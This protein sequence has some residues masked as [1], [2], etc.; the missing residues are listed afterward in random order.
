MYSDVVFDDITYGIAYG[1]SFI[2]SVI[3]RLFVVIQNNKLIK[4]AFLILFFS[5]ILWLLLSVVLEIPDSV[6]FKNKI[7]TT[8]QAY[9]N[10]KII[11]R[12]P[13]FKTHFWTKQEINHSKTMFK[14]N[15]E[16]TENSNYNYNIPTVSKQ[17][18]FN[19]TK[20]KSNSKFDVEYEDY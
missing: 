10:S 2:Y 13:K 4:Y 5:T 15:V 9:C 6:S 12:L 11:K 20:S 8:Y 7:S 16:S 19:Y 1:M 17:A 14:P 18:R 3:Q